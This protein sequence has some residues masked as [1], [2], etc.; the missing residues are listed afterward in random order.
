MFSALVILLLLVGATPAV[1]LSDGLIVQALVGGIAAIAIAI[2][3]RAI[4]PGEAGYLATLVRPIALLAA[5]PAIWMLIQ[6][7]P[8]QAFGIANPMWQSAATAL[9][10]PVAGSISIDIGATALSLSRYF[11]AMGI[12]FLGAAVAIDRTRAER[13]LFMLTA[14]T[15]AIAVL[16]IAQD[17]G[18]SLPIGRIVSRSDALNSAALGIILSV[19]AAVRTFERHETRPARYSGVAFIAAFAGCLAAFT[20]C[21]IAVLVGAAGPTIFSVGCGLTIVAIVILI[22][23]L[24]IGP[25]G[26]A[27]IALAV[28][29]VA[30]GIVMSQ[31]TA[32]GKHPA[33]AFAANAASPSVT[34]TG[35]MLTDA[36]WIGTGAGTFSALS[37]IYRDIDDPVT[38]ISPPTS[39]A[40]I[41]IELGGPALCLVVLASVGLV[42]LLLR[43][44]LRRGRDS[45]YPMAGAGCILLLL[46]LGFANAGLFGTASSILS[47]CTLGLALAQRKSRTLAE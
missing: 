37:P 17:L 40:K 42:L 28:I 23:R 14:A 26:N 46:V 10:R 33:I 22:R 1:V 15:T 34:I 39:A 47:A 36:P 20:V 3:S 12:A 45:F 18:L 4:R 6:V 25:W 44:A 8:L 24:G 32:R 11:F 29:G 38:V 43:G 30:T 31:L 41:A 5:I 13:L 19:A 7:L 35:R 27:A 16:L 21:S 2:V 9:G